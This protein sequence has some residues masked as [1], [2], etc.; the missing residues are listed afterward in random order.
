MICF[1]RIRLCITG[2]FEIKI[3]FDIRNIGWE[4]WIISE[5]TLIIGKGKSIFRGLAHYYNPKS[6][7]GLKHIG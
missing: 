7:R 6:K 4:I 1:L 3:L 5:L 2:L